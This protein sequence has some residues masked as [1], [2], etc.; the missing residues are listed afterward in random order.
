L[1]LQQIDG[2]QFNLIHTVMQS[3]RKGLKREKELHVFV[4]IQ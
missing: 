4:V 3:S 2:P 1:L